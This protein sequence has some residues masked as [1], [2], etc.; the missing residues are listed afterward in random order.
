MR[1]AGLLLLACASCRQGMAD[2]P[3]YEP[4]EVNAFFENPF[5]GN[6]NLAD[7]GLHVGIRLPLGINE[8]EVFTYDQA[9]GTSPADAN[10]QFNAANPGG[11]L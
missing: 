5:D 8:V 3:R 6:G 7:S 11:G 9:Y 1:S 4:F 2:Q 10:A